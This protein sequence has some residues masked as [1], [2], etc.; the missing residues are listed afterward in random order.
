[1]NPNMEIHNSWFNTLHERRKNALVVFKDPEYINVF[2]GVIDKYCDSAH[3]IYELLQNADDAKAT[4]VEM[5]LTKDRF[6][7]THN[8]KVRFTVSDPAKAE[9]D[10]R[11][12][13]LGH[14]NAITAIGFSSKNQIQTDNLDDIK[15]GKFG[16]GFKAV[17]QYTTTPYIYDNPFC[18]KIEDYIVPTRLTD[19]SFQREGRTVFV[20]PFDRKDIPAKQAYEDIEQKIAT[21]EYPQLFLFNVNTISWN[22]PTQKGK[23]EKKQI[24]RYDSYNEI[25]PVLYE[26]NNPRGE[27][28][29]IL[30]MSR[31]V[32]V[33][34]TD[35][36]HAIA[37]GYI[38]DNK[39]RINTEVR[40]NL[41]CF[42][43]TQ[44][45]IETCYIIHAPFAL[46]DNR[47]QIKRKNDVN[48]SLLKSI[49]E[50]AAD[51]IVIL[52]DISIKTKRTL[53]GDNIF[54]LMHHNLESI[55]EKT[56]SYYWMKSDEITFV[57]YYKKIVDEEPVFLSRQK[58]Y[59]TKDC[60]WWADDGMR[61]LLT[62]EQLDYLTKCNQKD[63]VED[64]DDE[65][66][67]DFILCSL[68]TRSEDEMHRYGI[69]RMT[70]SMLAEKLNTRFINSQSE[71]WLSQLY[72]YILDK[73]LIEEYKLNAGYS[74]DAPM[75]TAKIIKNECGE[76]VA[77]YGDDDE[78]CVFFKTE[79]GSDPESTINSELYES[80]KE[81][82][83]LI[84]ELGVQEP[85]MFD[86]IRIQLGKE[87]DQKGDNNLLSNIIRYYNSCDE[88]ESEE[89]LDLVRDELTFYCRSVNTNDD[90]DDENKW[91]GVDE[92]IADHPMLLEYY[93]ISGTEGK[94]HIDRE[95]YKDAIKAVGEKKFNSFLEEFDF[96]IYPR[97][98]TESAPLKQEEYRLRPEKYYSS[99]KEVSTLEGLK[100]VLENMESSVMPKELSHYIWDALID[101]IE[102][103][104]ASYENKAIFINDRGT[105]FYYKSHTHIWQSCTLVEWLRSY[106]WLYI[107]DE[108]QSIDEGVYKEE[109]IAELYPYNDKL[110]AKLCIDSSPNVAERESIAQMSEET[111]EAFSFGD[112]A[113][114]LGVTSSEELAELIQM[115]RAAKQANEQR[116][117]KAER[118]K[119]E[120]MED[121]LPK[122]K[123]S[124]KFSD[125]D[126]SDADNSHKTDQPK[127]ARSKEPVNLE[128]ALAG[129]EEKANLQRE[130]I[131]TVMTLRETVENAE[132]YSYGW[133]QALMALE[134]QSNGSVS[135]SGKHSINI[136]FERI[137][138]DKEHVNRI[139]LSGASRNIPNMLEDVDGIPVTFY[140]K[141]GDKQTVVFDN[142]SVKE[143]ALIVR[144][145]SSMEPM[146]QTIIA[147][148]SLIGRA[149]IDVDKPIEL[150]KRWKSLI[151]N[152]PFESEEES[153]KEN[154][155]PDLKFIFGPPGT[156]KTTTLARRII[157]LMEQKE[158]CRILVLAPTNKACDVLTKKIL[159]LEPETDYWLWRFVSTM[160][161][162]LEDE[163]VV[164]QRDSDIMR[165]SQVCV[166]STMAR[167][168][169]DGFDDG[170]LNSLDWDY[171]I[172]DEAS[173]IPLYQMLPPIFNE[174]SGEI[175]IAGDPFQIDP[176]V[177]IDLW[178]EENIY[179][180]IDLRNFANPKT[181]PVQFDVELLMTQYRSI[182]VIGELYS[183]Y[184]YEGKLLHDRSAASHRILNMGIKESPLNVIS[185]PVTKDSIFDTKRLMGSNIHIYS[186]LFTFE[187]LKYISAQLSKDNSGEPIKIGVLS[188]YGVEIQSIQKLYNQTCL[189]YDNVTVSFGTSHG[190]QGDQCDVVIAVMNP[191]SSG[192]KR[193]SEL[194]F[195]NKPNILNVAV[196]RA[197]DY[198]FLIMPEKNYELFPM[199][200]ELKKLG[201]IMIS[202]RCNK[203]YTSDEIEK[204]MFGKIHHIEDNT[205]VT[206]HQ[207]TNIYSDQ[208]A[209]YEVRVGEQALD[210]Q[211]ND[212][213]E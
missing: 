143:D 64:E 18:F 78:L 93:S 10:R 105:Y 200:H 83:M 57:D 170:L 65:V 160:D 194:T 179:K 89:L 24:E 193:N 16:V 171:V 127:P 113:K 145:N 122:R 56:Y 131:E 43:P 132:K 97:V 27:K 187:F 137:L 44:E 101:R 71:E 208:L 3:F 59:I 112:T 47:Q 5:V 15:I 124:E 55:Q 133:F 95:Y 176:I 119:Q 100:S 2:N 63:Y 197:K 85:S 7:F 136:L 159:E 166:V 69:D 81:F 142:A 182:P 53:L 199:L 22:T 164:Y 26:I 168:S 180:M 70:D 1:M 111:Q 82:R 91:C 149:T 147:N 135:T 68:N 183:Q 174:H 67:Y 151:E 152:L 87:L 99:S 107:N 109:L 165:Q 198:L 20:I 190:F 177:N 125:S 92:I 148:L 13:R 49:G 12:N 204:I 189:P 134:V 117:A 175:W 158:D 88:D 192:L 195:I 154:I 48:E 94:Y 178:K 58:E 169:F 130:E 184:M 60:G 28:T 25:T 40:P 163:E 32:V 114:Q 205:Y 62:T 51:S 201:R 212:N 75:R 153:V 33:P 52:K 207:T 157:S 84:K 45:N 36:K 126:F 30:L 172:I 31:K 90:G 120:E 35:Q 106:N 17:F 210:I 128:E 115:G 21:L 98:V 202:T 96:P 46:V 19:T 118:R 4:E 23:I 38:L 79:S 14:I 141:N 41:N 138:A 191:P 72:K 139:V 161:P 150:I 37:I 173:M 73:R 144:G 156:G 196:S 80:N 167:Y 209:K 11:R 123:K 77:P 61:K 129:F 188:P 140:F 206:T 74:S 110:I 146:I 102:D 42:F 9:E 213:V 186:V 66:I 6:I 86:N 211:I 121:I 108:L 54:A 203:F 116:Q 103:S 155:R 39:G 29:K 34:E 185:F 76:F 104:Y 162:D 8:G 50:L 181:T